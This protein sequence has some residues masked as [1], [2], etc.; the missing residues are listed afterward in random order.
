MKKIFFYPLKKNCQ[1]TQK[2]LIFH[3]SIRLAGFFFRTTPPLIGLTP[4]GKGSD[5]PYGHFLRLLST[6]PSVQG[7]KWGG[8]EKQP[9]L[10][11][12][13][14][15]LMRSF[16]SNAQSN[17]RITHSVKQ[18]W[19]CPHKTNLLKMQFLGIRC[20]VLVPVRLFLNGGEQ[21]VLMG[22]GEVN[23][24]VKKTLGRQ[25]KTDGGH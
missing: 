17:H 5:D 9:W 21:N 20:I 22:R 3:R 15:I 4:Q 11:L 24:R 1:K 19:I 8:E 18:L 23:Q 2:N 7:S 14:C 12:V 25:D 10:L 6:N 16:C 13:F